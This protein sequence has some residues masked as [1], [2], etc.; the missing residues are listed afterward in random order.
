MG[1]LGRGAHPVQG[2]DVETVLVTGLTVTEEPGPGKALDGGPLAGADSLGTHAAGRRAAAFDLD[3]GDQRAASGHQVEVVAAEPE[4][5]GLHAPTLLG[6]PAAGHKLRLPAIAMAGV[7]PEVGRA[8]G[9]GHANNLAE[10]RR[11]GGH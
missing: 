11:E 4:P 5:M 9:S 6:E 3:E 1:Q 7:S 10:R 8:A 2:Q